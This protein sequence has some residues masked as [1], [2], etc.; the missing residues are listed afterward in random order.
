MRGEPIFRGTHP[1]DCA[2][3]E[4]FQPQPLL[5][6]EQR[7][8]AAS[9]AVCSMAAGAGARRSRSGRA[10][11]RGSAAICWVLLLCRLRVGGGVG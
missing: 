7:M 5:A 1:S 9:S 2:G 11:A 4:T 10:A 6:L 8:G 3:H